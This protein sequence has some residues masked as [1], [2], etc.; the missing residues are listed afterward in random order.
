LMRAPSPDAAPSAT[1]LAA[2]APA[3]RLAAKPDPAPAAP[4][5]EVEIVV[6]SVPDDASISLLVPGSPAV[7]TKGHAALRVEPA[8][9]VSIGVWHAGYQARDR[10]GIVTEPTSLRLSLLPLAK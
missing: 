3:P 10:E 6:E 8:T 1:Q 9:R 7:I 4:A 5:S 2:S